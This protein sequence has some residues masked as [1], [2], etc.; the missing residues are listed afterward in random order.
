[1][2][3]R[4]LREA[5]GLYARADLGVPMLPRDCRPSIRAARLLYADIGRV[6]RAR[7]CDSVSSRAVVSRARKLG[8]VV[9]AS[10]AR[11]SDDREPQAGDPP[12]L[13]EVRFL[14]SEKAS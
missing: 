6:V 10:W 12:P 13:D 4:V 3:E 9:K 7:G 1:V 2:I 5:D 14:L 8:L 11:F